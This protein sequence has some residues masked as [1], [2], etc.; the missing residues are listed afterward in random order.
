MNH[1]TKLQGFYPWIDSASDGLWVQIQLSIKINYHQSRSKEVP[2]SILL[3]GHDFSDMGKSSQ[4]GVLKLQS[5]MWQYLKA[6]DDTICI[7]LHWPTHLGANTRKN[8]IFF[9]GA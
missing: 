2:H 5:K 8:W 9:F 3:L 1:K 4:I 6:P 7:L